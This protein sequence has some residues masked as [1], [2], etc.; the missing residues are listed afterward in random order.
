MIFRKNLFPE[1]FKQIRLD[2]DSLDRTLLRSSKNMIPTESGLETRAGMKLADNPVVFDPWEF[3]ESFTV[4]EITD[5]CVDVEGKAA[6][7]A[8]SVE[9]D[10][11]SN[12]NYHIC[13][14]FSDGNRKG[15]G[16][17][18]FSRTSSDTF[19]VPSSFVIYSGR[20]TV[21]YGI[22]FLARITYGN[23]PDTYRIYELSEDMSSWRFLSDIESYVPTVLINGHGDSVGA[24]LTN[25]RLELSNQQKLESFNMLNGRFFSYYTT[26]GHSHS[27]TLPTHSLIG[28]ISCNMDTDSA[29]SYEWI[30]PSDASYS[31]SEMIDEVAVRMHCDRTT[32]RIF[33]END[34]G[35]PYTPRFYGRENNLC[36][37]AS[38]D[39]SASALKV[40][41]MSRT[42]NIPTSSDS[43][44]GSVTVFSGSELCP[45]EIIWIDPENPL[46]FPE[47]CSLSVTQPSGTIEDM[48][49]VD[50][51]LFLFKKDKILSAKVTLADSYELDGIIRKILNSGKASLAKLSIDR[52]ISLPALISPKS[53]AL[54]D[55]DIYFHLKNGSVCKIDASLSF[56]VCAESVNLSPDFSAVLGN[57]YLLFSQKSCIVYDPE[58]RDNLFEWDFPVNFSAAFS[59]EGNTLF[60][61]DNGN[62]LIYSF[63]LTGTEDHY[64]AEND[65]PLRKRNITSH[66]KVSLLSCGRR[67]RLYSLSVKSDI[68]SP[69]NI[70]LFDGDK[71]LGTVQLS[72]GANIFHKS[73]VFNCLSAKLSFT[74]TARL[75]EI[76]FK[77][78][79]LS[80][81]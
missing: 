43:S 48:V 15:L 2:S 68:E 73:A 16:Y 47:S 42:C 8:V 25:D 63:T 22:Y 14:L 4:F 57:R 37:D 78:A 30:I 59:S 65:P 51:T 20:S 18:N 60:F 62:G 69:A 27:F 54:M 31:N 6:R 33:F 24:A 36:F 7:I 9:D 52:Q 19:G 81:L 66:V 28:K 11:Y 23:A 75:S 3:S 39:C 46:Y 40:C 55:R 45:E 61:A 26:D 74:G 70:E 79:K 76:C 29:R 34:V 32:G 72:K 64:L 50:R 38:K 12:I 49:S 53:V 13:A 5:L 1:A 77:Y 10:G 67:C 21:G 35:L 44:V 56:T 58:L 41:S 71:P 17:I 80:K